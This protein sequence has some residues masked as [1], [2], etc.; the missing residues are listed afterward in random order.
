MIKRLIWTIWTPISSVLKKAD[1][2][3]LSLSLGAI[4]ITSTKFC[5]IKMNLDV[6]HEVENLCAISS[7]L[8]AND[9]V[10]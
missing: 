2:L 4:G 3:N 7:E 1:E 10:L 8:L 6:T 9:Q 5:Q